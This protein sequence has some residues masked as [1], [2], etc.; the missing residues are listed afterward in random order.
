MFFLARG[1]SHETNNIFG[2]LGNGFLVVEGG[3]IQKKR[4]QGIIGENF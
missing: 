2:E 4:A 1:Q 3:T